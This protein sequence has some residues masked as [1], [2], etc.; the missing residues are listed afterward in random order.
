MA[1]GNGKFDST[2]EIPIPSDPFMRI[3]GQD[4]AVRIA[5]LVPLQRRHLLLVG[6]PGTG[7][8]LIARAIAS[9]LPKPRQEV[10]VLDNPERPE[11]P[12]VEIRDEAQAGENPSRARIGEEMDARIIP[13]PVAERLG[14]RCRRCGLLLP[15]IGESCA[16]CGALAP[17]ARP[18]MRIAAT[19]QAAPGKKEVVVYT[20]SEEGKILLLSESDIRKEEENRRK[21]RRKVLLPLKR[22]PFVQASGASEA[23]LLGDV[24]HDPY[25]SHKELGSPPFM[26]VVPGAVHEAHEGVL[27]ID[28]LSTLGNAQRHLL[29]A[30]QEKSFP[31]T[32]RNATSSGAAVR[33]D[34]VPCDFLMVGATNIN[35]LPGLLPALRSRINGDGYELLMNTTMPDNTENRWKLVQFIAQE[36]GR[37][38]RIPHADSGAVETIISHA[39]K[40]ARDV[41]GESD[42]LTL[43]LR[44]ISGVVK[45]AGD[46]AAVNKSVLIAK[47]DVLEA[48]KNARSVEEKMAER[49]GSAWRAGMSDFSA[50]ESPAGK[51]TR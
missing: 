36:I 1:G 17:Y 34:N 30:M 44:A 4:E 32:G 20:I 40:T 5:R 47:E 10:S 12:I 9:L 19:R 23:E 43:R 15:D 48:I 39:K 35:D 38:G 21:S 37:D 31:I 16:S 24:S 41:D 2:A 11:R 46:L 13:V 18:G 29:T 50:K 7:K 8:S 14:L 28:E 6:P 33:V 25:G 51:E 26:R 3:I 22:N 49:Y 42:A 27:F 45:L